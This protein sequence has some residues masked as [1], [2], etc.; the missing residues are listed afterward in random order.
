MYGLDDKFPLELADLCVKCGL[1]IPH[2]PTYTISRIESESPRGRIAMMAAIAADQLDYTPAAQEHL[3]HCLGCQACESACPAKVP[4]LSLLDAHRQ[5]HP[6]RPSRLTRIQI[7][8]MTGRISRPLMRSLSPLLTALAPAL[9]RLATALRMKRLHRQLSLIPQRPLKGRMPEAES[10]DVQLLAGCLGD[11]SNGPALDAFARCCAALGLTLDTLPLS[12]CCGALPQH[13]GDAQ[14]ARARRQAIHHRR[15]PDA[16]L[17]ALDSAC[18]KEMQQSDPPA[19]EEACSFLARQDWSALQLRHSRARVLVHQPC[20][21][22]NGLGG[23]SAVFHLLALIPGLEIEAMPDDQCCG[24]AGTHMLM[25][26]ERA[27]QLLQP[28]LREVRKRKPDFLVTTNIGCAMHIRAG[29]LR[30]SAATTHNDLPVIHP[31]ELLA[32]HLDA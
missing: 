23:N 24:A 26:P 18:A 17:V 29:L 30:E 15:Q 32:R 21:H 22:K 10:A 25:F 31:L 3:N 6:L 12:T 28:K 2:C 11:L 27:D 14:G 5:A 9:R 20:S 16:T 4:Y 19:T 7:A 13:M 1:C 8:L